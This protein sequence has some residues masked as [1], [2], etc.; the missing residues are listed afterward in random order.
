MYLLDEWDKHLEN[1]ETA[2][3]DFTIWRCLSFIG[4]RQLLNTTP[5]MR[6]KDCRLNKEQIHDR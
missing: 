1:D 6:N 2:Q 5:V 4:M 3:N